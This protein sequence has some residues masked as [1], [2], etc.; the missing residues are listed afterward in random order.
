M[1]ILA[2]Q[3]VD[4]PIAPD[5]LVIRRWSGRPFMPARFKRIWPPL[6]IG[7]MFV[8]EVAWILFTPPPMGAR[9]TWAV[10]SAR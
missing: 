7:T 4:L 1:T 9:H 3:A 2:E 10:T 6:M 8:L 5:G